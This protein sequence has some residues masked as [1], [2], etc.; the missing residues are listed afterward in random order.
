MNSEYSHES[1]QIVRASADS[2]QKGEFDT[3]P[4]SGIMASAR[5]EV[6]A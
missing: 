5:E 1:N 3:M 6:S 4:M 2:P